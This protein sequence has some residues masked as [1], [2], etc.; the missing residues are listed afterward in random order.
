MVQKPKPGQ[1][2]GAVAI[3]CGDSIKKATG[4]HQMSHAELE[5]EILCGWLNPA[6]ENIAIDVVGT[7]RDWPPD[8]VCPYIKSVIKGNE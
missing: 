3:P 1:L 4:Q 2:L 6:I 5:N 7:W 8:T